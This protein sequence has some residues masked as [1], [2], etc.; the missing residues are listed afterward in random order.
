MEK[1]KKSPSE[2]IIDDI[3]RKIEDGTLKPGQKIIPQRKMAKEYKTGIGS[4]R[5]ALKALKLLKLIKVRAGD[6]AYIENIQPFSLLYPLKIKSPLS[7]ED[8]LDFYRIRKML[9]VEAYKEVIDRAGENEIA[10][11]KKIIKNMKKYSEDIMNKS[12]FDKYLHE[13]IRFH[14]T[15]F[16]FTKNKFL[17]LFID[18]ISDVLIGNY[19]HYFGGFETTPKSQ[20]DHEKIMQAIIEKNKKDAEFYCIKNIDYTMKNIIK[21]YLNIDYIDETA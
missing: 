7:L 1:I 19:G 18:F 15:V 13:D 17:I 14:K 5:E 12:S 3:M 20:D 10:E 21:E 9:D 6:G 4:V 16:R 8:I 2:I 11:L